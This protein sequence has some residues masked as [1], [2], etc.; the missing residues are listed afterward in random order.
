MIN[1]KVS[2]DEENQYPKIDKTKMQKLEA[3]IK[4]EKEK[5]ELYKIKQ[6]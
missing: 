1:W 4:N 2:D 5:L 3:R 6:E